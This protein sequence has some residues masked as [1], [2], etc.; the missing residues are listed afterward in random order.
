MRRN[1]LFVVGAISATLFAAA[2][3]GQLSYS[4][5]D[6][7][8]LPG[9]TISHP[10]GINNQAQVTGF[11]ETHAF[12]WTNG[13]MADLGTLSGGSISTGVGINDLRQVVGDSQYSPQGGSIRHATL[14]SNG[15]ATD[16]GFL[17][18]WGNYSRGNGINDGGEVVGHS[19]PD[20]TTTNTR[21]FI[22]DATNGMRDLGTLGGQYSRANSINDSS[23]VTGT[24]QS[25]GGFGSF[26]AFVWDAA[27]G[28]RDLGT[29]A[30][31]T[32][33]GNFINA[34]GH[35]TGSSTINTF[36]NR[37]HAFLYNGSTMQDLGA[38][39]DNDFLSDRS[40]GYGINIHDEVVGSTYRPYTG[41]ALYQIAFVYRDGQMF[42]LETLVDASGADYRLYTAT[43]INDAG[44]IAVDAI[45]IS[46]G[47]LRAVLLTPGAPTPTPTPTPTPSPTPTPCATP[48]HFTN[49]T[50]I[51]IPASGTVGT[52]AP[53]PSNIVIP[54]LAGNV[55]QV[56]VKLNGFNHIYPDDVDIL[57]VGPGGQ[58]AII[59]SDVGGGPDA[60]NVTLTLD[61]GA[62]NSLPDA[63][64]VI[65]GIFKPTNFGTADTF[66]GPAPL[67]LGGSALS[68]FNGT[69][70]TGTW[71]LYIMDDETTDSG[72]LAGGWELN[73][74]T[75]NCD[76]VTI[77]KAT[78]SRG[79]LSV[80]ATDSDPTGILQVYETAT[81]TLI[82]SL[83]KRGT[84]YTGKFRLATNPV[85]I[86][87]KSSAGGSAT[88]TVM[89]R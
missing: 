4:L 83:T 21:A 84:K 59:L 62:L 60:V 24:A 86:T 5:T 2:A 56:T 42:D 6:L 72:S 39:G 18:S 26:H 71:S 80:Q 68:V 87:V 16:L 49:T 15:T 82:G 65:S 52:A 85:T 54:P 25:S 61:D 66:S 47:N 69:N 48:S 7:G 3:S 58:N 19:G 37:E 22:W 13:V 43:G 74:T 79:T 51:S 63:T 41:G 89:S 70:P 81:D 9:K 28:M 29:L 53:Y 35:V 8:T 57:L 76:I 20:L 34:N 46:T 73:I 64:Q 17:P 50:P 14:W 30:G 38:I 10:G 23:M 77:T 31:T 12:L 88:V 32:S 33:Y 36:D 11:T 1:I 45:K 27:N 75:D 55:T 78:Y 40:F 67:P 44:Q